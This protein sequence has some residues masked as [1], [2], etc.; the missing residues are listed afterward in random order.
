MMTMVIKTKKKKQILFGHLY[1]TWRSKQQSTRVES[2]CTVH[3]IHL[4]ARFLLNFSFANSS[5]FKHACKIFFATIFRFSS[6]HST[7]NYIK[8]MFN[9]HT[10]LMTLC[11]ITPVNVLDR[12]KWWHINKCKYQF[13]ISPM[14]VLP[15]R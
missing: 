4:R 13:F 9:S 2:V 7:L 3:N 5:L 8:W 6:C 1:M 10:E 15:H 12:I 11:H 14:I